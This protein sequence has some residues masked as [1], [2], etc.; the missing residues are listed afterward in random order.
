MIINLSLFY[1]YFIGKVRKL[2]INFVE[3][4]T[5]KMRIV[6]GIHVNI[7]KRIGHIIVWIFLVILFFEGSINR[8]VGIAWVKLSSFC[9]VY[10]NL[11]KNKNSFHALLYYYNNLKKMH[12][13]NQFLA[14]EILFY[15]QFLNNGN[16]FHKNLLF[17][18]ILDMVSTKKEK[19]IIINRGK[20]DFIDENMVVVS[21]DNV[22]LGRITSVYDC[23]SIVHLLDN[24]DQYISGIINQGIKVM[25]RGS[26]SIED[27]TMEVITINNEYNALLEN[28]MVV[29][30]SGKGLVYPPG[31]VIG[32]LVESQ[33]NSV[34]WKVKNNYDINTLLYCYVIVPTNHKRN[35]EFLMKYK[36]I[37]NRE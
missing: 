5:L 26:R 22:V 9:F 19:F 28:N 20:N 25:L 11:F 31:Y 2:R 29:Y 7:Q 32:T 24:D 27:G 4:D 35:M 13:E 12:A 34:A 23:F 6:E 14:Q 8:Y 16:T 33:S 37:L 10:I 17:S 30:S 3:Y 1:L 36:N 18:E 21:L 15:K